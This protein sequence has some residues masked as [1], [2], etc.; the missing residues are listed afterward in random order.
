MNRIPSKEFKKELARRFNKPLSEIEEIIESQFNIIADIIAAN[1]PVEGK[2]K[3]IF[4]KEFGRFGVSAF[5]KRKA[6]IIREVSAKSGKLTKRATEFE[7]VNDVEEE[8]D[9]ITN[10]SQ[11]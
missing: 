10:L 7:F 4:L 5:G 6:N 1:N 2:C 8:I 11:Q 3:M 9:G